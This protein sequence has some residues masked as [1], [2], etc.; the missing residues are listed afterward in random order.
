MFNAV[1][2]LK[3]RLDNA[4]TGQRVTR[5]R[6]IEREGHDT[7]IVLIVLENTCHNEKP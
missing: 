3:H 2:R 5:L 1:T 6:V 7:Q 4:R